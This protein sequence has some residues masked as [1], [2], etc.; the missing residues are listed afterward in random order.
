M[1]R[2]QTGI[3]GLSPS[4]LFR[5]VVEKT[6]GKM[7]AHSMSQQYQASLGAA[8]VAVVVVNGSKEVSWVK[9]PKNGNDFGS[10]DYWL[11]N[12]SKYKP[13]EI[14]ISWDDEY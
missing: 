12:F 5:L 4:L 11:K 2:R 9:D 6:E 1:S 3:D 14:G 10:S 7:K 8:E 13:V